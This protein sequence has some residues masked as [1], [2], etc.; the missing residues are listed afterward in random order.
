M[1]YVGPRGLPLDEFLSWSA[2]S[3]DAALAWQAHEAARCASCGRHPD[4]QPRHPH[5][6]V[7]PDCAA[8]AATRRQANPEQGEHAVWAPG[9]RTDCPVCNPKKPPQP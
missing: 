9:A 8:L 7:C 5:I 2:D 1:G 6:E 4:D 3:Q